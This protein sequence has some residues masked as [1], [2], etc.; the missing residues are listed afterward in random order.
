M[1][2]NP[3]EGLKF[4]GVRMKAIYMN[5]RGPFPCLLKPKTVYMFSKARNLLEYFKDL[6]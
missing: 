2:R 3:F 6:P 4:R 1:G 5:S